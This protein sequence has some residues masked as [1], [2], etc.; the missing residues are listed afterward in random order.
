MSTA[1]PRLCETWFSIRSSIGPGVLGADGFRFDLAAVLGNAD[2]Q[3]GYSF[4]RDDPDN[5]LNRAVA[6]LPARPAAGGA[7]VDLI[8]EPYTGH[9]PAVRAA[10]GKFPGGLV[11]VERPLPRR[12]SRLPE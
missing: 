5:I 3:G 9:R 7:G 11:G 12:V 8:A 6:E 1:P 4:N 2:A 10:A